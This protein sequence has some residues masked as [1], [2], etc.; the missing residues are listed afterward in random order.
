M[1]F[2]AC[3]APSRPLREAFFALFATLAALATTASAQPSGQRGAAAIYLS[4]GTA[5]IA[6]S[7]LDDR[8]A[9]RGHPTFG[10]GAA[11]VGVGAY[12]ILEGGVMLGGEW[13]GLIVGE[14]ERAGREVGLGG[15]YGTLGVG[16]VFTPSPRLRVYP[17]LGLGGGGMGLWFEREGAP[18]G[19]DEV[20]AN[21]DEHGTL[22]DSTRETVLSHSSFAVDIGGGAEFLPG[23]W[24]RGL[25]V[26][27][28]AGYLAAPSS[29]R[30]WLREREVTG[31]PR[32]SVAGPY[33]RV[34]LG[35]GPRW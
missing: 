8:L 23:G 1:R 30:W 11:S 24:A 18:V 3:F 13:N 17:R 2:F 35:G 22:A 4:A 7:Q 14:R 33:L 10:R 15:G 26:G 5:T 25:Q 29:D 19:F 16:Y 34:T 12:L 31:G 21:P 9:A 27:I 20:L 32:A 28:R 6:T